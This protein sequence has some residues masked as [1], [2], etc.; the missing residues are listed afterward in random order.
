MKTF[1]DIIALWG[2]YAALARDVNEPYVTVQQWHWRNSIPARVWP[3]VVKA[4]A[5]RGYAQVTLE[6]LAALSA[7][8]AT[9]SVA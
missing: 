2:S 3:I 8:R 1:R 6:A 4:A 7:E 5:D 9:K